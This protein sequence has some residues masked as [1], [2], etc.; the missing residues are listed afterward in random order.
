[1]TLGEEIECR[2][3]LIAF[4]F[5]RETGIDI[6]HLAEKHRHQC[7][8]K[9]KP[10]TK[11]DIQHSCGVKPD[12]G[13]SDEYHLHLDVEDSLHDPNKFYGSWEEP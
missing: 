1:M 8:L 4:L 2:R 13:M 7:R 12:H 10:M 3:L 5:K 9:P 6:L 11:T